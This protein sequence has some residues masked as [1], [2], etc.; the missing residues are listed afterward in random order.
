MVC[1]R[2]ICVYTLHKGD[3][4]GDDDNNNILVKEQYDFRSKLSTE[5][6]SYSLI[7]EIL[8]ALKIK[9]LSVT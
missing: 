3:S 4:G 7:S 2:N 8:N 9:T 5:V 1:L 6:A